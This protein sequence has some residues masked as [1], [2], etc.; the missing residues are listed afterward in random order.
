MREPRE[1][2]T[3]HTGIRKRNTAATL[4]AAKSLLNGIQPLPRTL[5]DLITHFASAI[6]PLEAEYDALWGLLDI[7]VEVR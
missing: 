6:K 3:C 2:Q 7:N 1:W 4:P 5:N